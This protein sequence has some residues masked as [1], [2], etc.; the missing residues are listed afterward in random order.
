[1]AFADAGGLGTA[2][3]NTSGTTLVITTTQTANVGDLIVVGS[4]WDNTSTGDTDRSEHLKVTDSAGNV[5]TIVKS[6]ENAQAAAAAGAHALLAICVVK[7]QLS[8]GG[9]ITVT[10][11]T[12][13]T[14]KAASANLFTISSSEVAVADCEIGLHDAADPGALTLPTSFTT[15]RSREYLEIYVLAAEGPNTDAYTWDSNQTQMTDDGS[16]GSMHLRWS[17]RIATLTTDT[18]DVTST[19]ADRDYAAIFAAL[20]EYEPF[21]FPQTSTLDTFTRANEDP[22][23]GGGNWETTAAANPLALISNA[24]GDNTANV[25]EMSN[26]TATFTDD[27]ECGITH[28]QRNTAI[29]AGPGLILGVQDQGSNN[30]D[31]Y[32][33]RRRESL[34]G[35]GHDL[36]QMQRIL[37]NAVGRNMLQWI[38]LGAPAAGDKYGFRRFQDIIEVWWSPNGSGAWSFLGAQ[39]EVGQL[40]AGGKIGALATA[41]SAVTGTRMD[42]FFGGDIDAIDNLNVPFISSVTAVHP[43]TLKPQLPIPFIASASS[44]FAPTLSDA[45]AAAELDIPFISSETRLFPPMSLFTDRVG[46]G[47]GNGGELFT[48]VLAPNGTVETATLAFDI[49][50]TAGTLQ[51]TGGG[52]FPTASFVVTIDDEVL[53]LAPRSGANYRILER[54]VSNTT[55]AAHSAGATVT[56]D[57]TYD[58]AIAAGDDINAEFT[59]DI[60]DS[61]S[62]TY[63]GWLI[64]FDASQAYIGSDRYPMHVTEVVGVFAAGDGV[65]GTSK[66][67]GPQPNAIAS[68]AATSDDCPAAL[69]N[70]ARIQTDIVIG[71]VAVVR[72]TNPEA[73]MLKLGPRATSLQSWFGLK[74]VD[75]DDNDVT[76][77]DPN[78]T[79]VDGSVNGE[80]FDP[81][82]PGIAPDTGTPTPNDVPY[83]SVTLDGD[84][85]TFTHG[86]TPSPPNFEEQ[87]WPMCALAVRQG[88]RRIP[89]WRS[90]DWHDFGWVYAGFAADATFCQMLVNRNGIVFP[91]S[92][93]PDVSLPG[94]QDI[95]GPDAV[96][97][98]GDYYFGA[99]WYVAIFSTPYLVVGPLIGQPGQDPPPFPIVPVV[100]FPGGIPHI[101]SPEPNPQVEGGSGGGISPPSGLAGIFASSGEPAGAA[102]GAGSFSAG[103]VGISHIRKRGP[104]GSSS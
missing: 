3:S 37:N 98:V 76:L 43:P 7:T 26:W 47:A 4:A 69:S 83:T 17:Y 40:P 100:S 104:M 92:G 68:A 73:S 24:V 67:D 14:A 93:V 65:T 20:F 66:I 82:G 58:M 97:D 57:D 88:T 15:L 11:D 30:W 56:W 18:V 60:D 61:G 71:D 31:G 32:R 39:E 34:V 5:Y 52:G 44:V 81:L 22:V 27:T 13:R 72:Y 16:A 87:G 84:E 59:A 8:S 74:R 95:D 70:P 33:L 101:D 90:W 38:G 45:A 1:M 53:R 103:M 51:V 46:V 55:P 6:V 85:R 35:S 21:G 50:D 77:T 23:S 48:I 62:F 36:L 19:T 28:T 75:S 9:T 80:W 42:D 64:A 102:G 91:I 29:G 12:S 89:F 41:G 99:S 86:G 96:W 49:S 79:V 2:N 63:P 78:G 94:P 25:V 54:G 10:S